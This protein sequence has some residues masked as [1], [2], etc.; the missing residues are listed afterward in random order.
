MSERKVRFWPKTRSFR[1]KK[2]RNPYWAKGAVSVLAI[3]KEIHM[4]DTLITSQKEISRLAQ[5]NK[6]LFN[7]LPD[8]PLDHKR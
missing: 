8:M 4:Q 1:S 3:V 2:F 6:I 5:N 7:L